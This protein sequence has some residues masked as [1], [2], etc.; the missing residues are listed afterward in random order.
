V[1]LLP[2]PLTPSPSKERGSIIE[3]GLTPSWTP[4]EGGED[5][6]NR[7]KKA[8]SESIKITGG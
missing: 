7:P 5:G 6:E 2:H 8:V 3:R 1:I 4:R